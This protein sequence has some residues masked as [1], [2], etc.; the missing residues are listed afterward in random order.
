MRIDIS[1][2]D[3]SLLKQVYNEVMKLKFILPILILVLVLT[4]C[5]ESA[6]TEDAQPELLPDDS[7][8]VE[9]TAVVIDT[10]VAPTN[11]PEI[12]R[13]A[14]FIE[15]VGEVEFRLSSDMDFVSAGLEDV[16]WAGGQ[17][18]TGQDG[19][20]KLDLL[21]D[22]TIVRL[23]KH[24][25][26][27]LTDLSQDRDD[28]ITKINLLLGKLWIILNGGSLEIDTPSGIA[29]VQGSMMG[30][31]YNPD[32]QELGVTCLEGHCAVSNAFGEVDLEG[33]QAS[34]VISGNAPSDARPM[35][36]KEFYQWR[37]EVPEASDVLE[38][39]LSPPQDGDLSA[40]D[41]FVGAVG[42]WEGIDDEDGT[43]IS[44]TIQS[45]GSDMYSVYYYIDG[46]PNCGFD[47]T[48]SPYPAEL[49][50]TGKADGN[51]L[52]VT[53]EAICLNGKGDLK[54]TF[55]LMFMYD[56]ATDTLNGDMP[57]SK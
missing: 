55:T 36:P 40:A 26:F 16:I 9:D 37:E 15:I 31:A 25:T 7:V 22:G 17:A 43:P 28:P 52:S 18:L 12:V 32:T 54:R 49:E 50:G 30:V 51:F 29:S 33:G 53:G 41:S 11:T 38:E 3:Y 45:L 44:F 56:A 20:A 27:T 1:R 4:A 5:G 57:R 42:F 23:S 34:E 2:L 8:V 35:T 39:A 24:T 47:E 14:V 13:Q 46:T 48:G 19:N 21:P 6:P 10:E